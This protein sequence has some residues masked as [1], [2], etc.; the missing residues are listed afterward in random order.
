MPDGAARLRTVVFVNNVLAQPTVEALVR[1]GWVVGLCTAVLSAQNA[2]LHHL[3]QR[4]GIPTYEADRDR[5]KFA[6]QPWLQELRPDLLLTFTFPHKLPLS[7]L[8]VPPLGCFNVHGGKLPQYRGPQPV[9]WEILNRETEGAVTVHRMDEEFDHGDIV[10]S[11]S[12]PIAPEETHGL[13]TMRLAFAA[14][15]AVDVLLG[16]LIA[17]GNNLPTRP[18]DEAQAAFQ[19]RPT[20]K[21]LVIRWEEQSGAQIRG[22]V[23]AGNPWNQGAFASVRGINLRLTDVTLKDGYG[24]DARPP[25]TILTS[26]SVD[27]VVI[28]CRDGSALQ[29]D[30]VSMDEGIFPGRTLAAFGIQAGERFVAAML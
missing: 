30:V 20:F 23:K 19:P 14:A 13:H 5:L 22:L 26:N 9:F 11:H 28:N 15:G 8:S 24:D 7:V 1:G 17:H 21:D 10:V 3:A 4:A 6:C 29:L 2:S 27:G 16:G 18:Q 25:G 12:V